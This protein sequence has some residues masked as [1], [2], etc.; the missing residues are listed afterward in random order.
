M[1]T[2]TDFIKMSIHMQKLVMIDRNNQIGQISD[3]ENI[4]QLKPLIKPYIYVEQ[5]CP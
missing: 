3:G 4:F 5:T 1:N 2:L